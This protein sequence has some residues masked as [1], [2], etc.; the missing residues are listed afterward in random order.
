[1]LCISCRSWLLCILDADFFNEEVYESAHE[2]VVDFAVYRSDYKEDFGEIPEEDFEELVLETFR[3]ADLQYFVE[4]IFDQLESKTVSSEGTVTFALDF[5]YF[6]EKLNELAV[7]V[8]EYKYEK[9]DVQV[10]YE[11]FEAE[12]L[13]ELNTELSDSLKNPSVTFSIP[14]PGSELDE[15][16]GIAIAIGFWGGLLILLLLLGIVAL[17]IFRPWFVVLRWVSITVLVA[18]LLLLLMSWS[19]LFAPLA[20]FYEVVLK[21]FVLNLFMISIFAVVI[22]LLLLTRTKAYDAS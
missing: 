18:G 9:F 7:N 17:I 21:P 8:A 5:K 13:A 10:P 3:P 12:V 19:I 6:V 11:D 20:G 16:I 4:D 14:F 15:L 2:E 1:M 22:S